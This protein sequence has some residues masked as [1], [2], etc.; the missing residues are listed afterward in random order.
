MSAYPWRED[1][2]PGP[3]CNLLGPRDELCGSE[4]DDAEH[5]D[6]RTLAAQVDALTI[7]RDS[8]G[9]CVDRLRA[10][11]AESERAR[12]ALAGRVRELETLVAMYARGGVQ[13]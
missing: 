11:V 4:E 5:Y 13:A 7:E 2:A 1:E 8:L 6:A 9:A 3:T 10:E 12:A